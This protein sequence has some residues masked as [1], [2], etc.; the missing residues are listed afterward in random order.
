MSSIAIGT[1][2]LPLPLPGLL[3]LPL[4]D[5]VDVDVAVVGFMVTPAAS[6]REANDI[7]AMLDTTLPPLLPLL[8]VATGAIGRVAVAV[9]A[10]VLLDEEEEDADVGAVV[11]AAVV[12]DGAG[13]SELGVVPVLE[14][15]AALTL[16]SVVLVSVAVVGLVS[17][18]VVLPPAAALSRRL[19]STASLSMIS[20]RMSGGREK[21]TSRSKPEA[22]ICGIR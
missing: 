2:P 14:V 9:V 16:V 10:V 13:T 12:V 6:K 5:D 7:S 18:V 3:A 21:Y 4:D 15:A 1:L 8:T 17:G 22:A 20:R 19:L 11:A